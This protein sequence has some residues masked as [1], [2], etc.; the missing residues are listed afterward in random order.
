MKKQLEK[1]SILLLSF[2]LISSF[3]VSSSLPAMKEFFT[4]Y[5]ANQVEL[6]ISLPSFGVLAMLILTGVIEGMLSERRMI[7]TGL[8]LVSI[9]GLVPVFLQD[10]WLIFL[11]R[12]GLGMG[13]GL[14]NA[15]AISIISERYQGPERV[16]LLGLRGSAEVVGS[17]LFTL[18]VGQLLHYGWQM[19]FLIYAFALVV[20]IAYLLFVPYGKQVKK[21]EK[22][23]KRVSQKLTTWQLKYSIILAVIACIII[24]I[25]TAI[26]LRL[27]NQVID[28]G[29]GDAQRASQILSAMQLVGILSGI[30]FAPLFQKFKKNLLFIACLGFALGQILV[31]L[32]TNAWL[33]TLASLLAGFTYSICLTTIF[34]AMSGRIPAALLNKAT[35]YVLIGCNLGGALT[36]FVLQGLDLFLPS[37]SLIF[38]AFGLI[39]VLVAGLAYTLKSR[40]KGE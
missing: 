7:I 33:L 2:M 13:T 15:K 34:N 37:F 26:S 38:L 30:S 18:C 25:N 11:S 29:L 3:S 10:Y 31:A 35:A 39:M 32:S 8:L 36:P 5:S 40:I 24:C 16:Q 22:A 21:Q 14:I 1:V 27:P 19:S 9:C 6:L 20:L 28:S 23:E 17:A 12:L 4:S